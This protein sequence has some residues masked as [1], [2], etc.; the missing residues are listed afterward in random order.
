MGLSLETGTACV[1]VDDSGALTRNEDVGNK[2]E[3]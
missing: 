3:L 1:R 2:A